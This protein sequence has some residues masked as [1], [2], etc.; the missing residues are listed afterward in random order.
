L[1]RWLIYIILAVATLTVLSVAAFFLTVQSI[2]LI[3]GMSAVVVA[4]GLY[5][6]KHYN[7]E[8]LQRV[9]FTGIISMATTTLSFMVAN[10]IFGTFIL[11]ST[12]VILAIIYLSNMAKAAA[13]ITS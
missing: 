11:A 7:D 8:L 2:P 10:V 1:K 3:F 12:T 4:F 6:T 9:L 13:I 5:T